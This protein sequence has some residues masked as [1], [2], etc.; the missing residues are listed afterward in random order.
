MSGSLVGLL[1]LQVLYLAIG[2]AL[3][4]LLGLRGWRRL[5][6]AYMAG[7]AAVGLLA[8]ELVLIQITLGLVELTLL[9]LVVGVAA[10]LRRPRVAVRQSRTRDL[11]GLAPLAPLVALLGYALVTVGRRPLLEFD[12]WAIWGMK[13]RA[14]YQLGGTANPVFTSDAYPP[15]QHPLLFPSLEAIG[16]RAMGAFDPALF[17][18]QLVLVAAAF[19]FALL[20]LLRPRVPLLLAGLVTLAIVSAAGTIQQVSNGLADAPLAFFVVLGVAALARWLETGQ[21][22][23]LACAAL[24]LGAAAL[25]KSEGALFALAAAVALLGTLAVWDRTRLAR[26]GLAMLAVLAV[27][28]PWR[29]FIAAHHLPNPEYSLGNA[30]SPGYLSDHA[31]RVGPAASGLADRIASGRFGFLLA[32][33]LLGLATALV[34]RRYRELAFAGAWLALS[35]LGLVLVYWISNVPVHLTLVW[36]GDRTVTSI[37]LGGAA[38]APLLA[39]PAWAELSAAASEKRRTRASARPTT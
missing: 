2:V 28:V 36:S 35:F 10:F 19:S 18:V 27:L 26:A 4:Q 5:G 25:T 21:T 20:D 23:V 29:V 37:V 33:I 12:G 38:L 6:L 9:A 8:A 22:P 13:A 15:L 3:L 39:A 16:F 31:D 7:L 30:A 32:L 17:H 34:S 1:Y 14:L 11:L 24:F